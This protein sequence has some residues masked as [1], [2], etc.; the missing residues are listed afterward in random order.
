MKWK[1]S[2]ILTLGRPKTRWVQDNAE[3]NNKDD[4]V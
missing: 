3:M 2:L 4:D 1:Y